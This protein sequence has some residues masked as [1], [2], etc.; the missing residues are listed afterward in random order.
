MSGAYLELPGVREASTGALLSL[1]ED[2]P[3]EERLHGEDGRRGMDQ[4]NHQR[5]FP[6]GKEKMDMA[7]K[8]AR[9]SAR[10]IQGRSSWMR[11]WRAE[12]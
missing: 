8:Q 1:G 3:C 9:R 7:Y 4:E 5:H 11:T 10:L 2:R 12:K 6:A